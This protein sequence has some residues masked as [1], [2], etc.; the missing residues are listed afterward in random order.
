MI[1]M[2]VG[3]LFILASKIGI[4]GSCITL[5]L[6]RGSSEE[7]EERL[8]V[9]GWLCWAV[10]IVGSYQIVVYGVGDNSLAL[11]PGS[12][13]LD[14]YIRILLNPHDNGEAFRSLMYTVGPL[15]AFAVCHAIWN[16]FESHG[17]ML[18]FVS[19]LAGI[20]LMFSLYCIFTMTLI[21]GTPQSNEAFGTN[22]C[23]SVSYTPTEYIQIQK[24]WQSSGNTGNAPNEHTYCPPQQQGYTGIIEEPL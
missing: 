5:L 9:L 8:G 2:L 10:L 22:A 11:L 12:T 20:G 21:G 4:L 14:P 24:S 17:G 23:Y 19:F 3:I 15:V 13:V 6:L 16:A 1:S 18:G 7:M